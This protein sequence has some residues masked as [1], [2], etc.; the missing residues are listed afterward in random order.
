MQAT[1]FA[2]DPE[3]MGIYD[4]NWLM[5]LSCVGAVLYVQP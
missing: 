4:L 5:V 1:C 3:M 2:Y